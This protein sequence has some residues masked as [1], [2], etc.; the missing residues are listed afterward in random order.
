MKH[1]Y[2]VFHQDVRVPAKF[3]V[4]VLGFTLSEEPC[5]ADA[6]DTTVHRGEL[7]VGCSRDPQADTRSRKPPVG[8]EIVLQ[9]DDVHAEYERA[10]SAGWPIEDA[11]QDRPWGMTDFRIFDPTGQY[12]RITSPSTT[13]PSASQA[14]N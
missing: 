9:M 5:P 2:E 14:S 4:T 1:G 12:I 7:R 8:S 13:Q 3:Y 10:Q 11:L 6:E